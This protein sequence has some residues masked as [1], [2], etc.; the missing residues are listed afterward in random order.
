MHPWILEPF[1]LRRNV[2]SNSAVIPYSF[3][4]SATGISNFHLDSFPLTVFE[5]HVWEHN[6]IVDI[7]D[8]KDRLDHVA[9]LLPVVDFSLQNSS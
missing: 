1:L 5:H 3:S 6:R 4:K 7:R 8:G 2:G 9:I